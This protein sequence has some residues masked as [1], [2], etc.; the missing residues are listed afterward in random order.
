MIGPVNG[1][2]PL[3][4]P[5][6]T[7]PAARIAPVEGERSFKE[8]LQ[9]SIEDVNRLQKEADGVLAQYVRGEATQDQV[10]IAFKK[11]QIAFEALLQIRN[12]L[13]SAFEEIQRMRI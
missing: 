1:L 3:Q 5:S 9:T 6:T 7:G 11:S 8:I 13:V 10:A 12:K 2:S 4:A